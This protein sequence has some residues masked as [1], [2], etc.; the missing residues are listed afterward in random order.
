MD[1]TKRGLEE[2]IEIKDKK[3]REEKRA[4]ED[5]YE[6]LQKAKSGRSKAEESALAYEK[7]LSVLKG[8]LK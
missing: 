5:I 6:E 4:Q 2:E 1:E 8:T 3:L 7:E